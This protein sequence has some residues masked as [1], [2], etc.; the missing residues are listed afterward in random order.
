MLASKSLSLHTYSKVLIFQL[1]HFSDF[2]SEKITK[3]VQYSEWLD[4]QLYMSEQNREPLV[5]AESTTHSRH[6]FAYIEAG[7]G[8]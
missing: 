1:K 6:F 3:H 5:H 8:H 4:M 2:F 7:D